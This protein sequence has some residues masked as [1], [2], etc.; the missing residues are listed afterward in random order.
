MD[1]NYLAKKVIWETLKQRGVL[2]RFGTYSD[3]EE[4]DFTEEIRAEKRHKREY[5]EWKGTLSGPDLIRFN[6]I[7]NESQ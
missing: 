2:K 7:F 6:T 5:Q 3:W 4:R 1:E